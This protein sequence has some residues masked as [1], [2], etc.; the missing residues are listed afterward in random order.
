MPIS[1]PFAATVLSGAPTSRQAERQRLRSLDRS[2]LLDSGDEERFDRLTRRAVTR[3]GVTTAII[4]LIAEDRLY[5]KSFVGNLPRTIDRDA[6]FCNVTIQG[7]D[8]LV[9]P[10][11]LAHPLFHDN[12]LVT[13]APFIRFYAGVPLRGPGG[14]FV[15]SMCILDTRPRELG[16]QG[17]AQLRRLAD[18]AEL[19]V[20]GVGP[21]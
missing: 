1:F 5:L 20:N 19:E 2:G 6:A 17:I 13:Q 11:L 14:W 9:V 12:P 8:P 10:D 15:G 16:G 18:E 21:S 3:F 4:S 7:E